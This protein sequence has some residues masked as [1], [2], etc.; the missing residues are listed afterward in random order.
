M[1][2]DIIDAKK[3][4]LNSF[5]GVLGVVGKSGGG[6]HIFVYCCIFMTKFFD[7]F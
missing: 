3:S 1:S 6:S 2:G 4:F 7:V 5:E